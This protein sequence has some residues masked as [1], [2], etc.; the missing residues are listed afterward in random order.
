MHVYKVSSYS[1]NVQAPNV[2]QDRLVAAQNARSI[3]FSQCLKTGVSGCAY[4]GMHEE[5]PQASTYN[6]S[7]CC[8]GA[9]LLTVA[10]H[11]L[12]NFNLGDEKI[13]M[14]IHAGLQPTGLPTL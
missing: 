13:G 9:R 6:S 8:L 2:H 11:A 7:C 14:C 3:S 4:K 10:A 5:C 12:I 1:A